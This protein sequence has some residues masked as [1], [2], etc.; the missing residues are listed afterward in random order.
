MPP[1]TAG[2]C[3]WNGLADSDSD[4]DSDLQ[5][6]AAK[7]ASPKSPKRKIIK[8]QYGEY[9]NVLLSDEEVKKLSSELP[10]W[11]NLVERLSEYMA[12]SGKHYKSHYATLRSWNRREPKQKKPPQQYPE[13]DLSGIL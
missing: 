4:S 12:S 8:H 6:S 10:D 1:P 13:D 7:A 9:K 3:I 2:D 11:L 5:R